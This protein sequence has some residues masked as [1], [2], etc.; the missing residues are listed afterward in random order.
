MIPRK[1]CTIILRKATMLF[2]S[3]LS[4]Q[5]TQR[6]NSVKTHSEYTLY[7]DTVPSTSANPYLFFYEL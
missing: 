6:F 5:I 4:S 1:T 7:L 3:L 2:M